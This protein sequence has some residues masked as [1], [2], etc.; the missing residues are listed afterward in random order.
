[1]E[2]LL[3]Y[4]ARVDFK[5]VRGEDAIDKL[6]L[7]LA[8]YDDPIRMKEANLSKELA[9]MY[10]RPAVESKKKRLLEAQAEQCYANR[11]NEEME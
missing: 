10:Y 6:N 7:R 5:D 1:M 2:I 11:P 8:F 3:S 4:G 9:A